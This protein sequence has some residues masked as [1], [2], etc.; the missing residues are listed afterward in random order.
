MRSW[1]F[2]ISLGIHLFFLG[3]LALCPVGVHIGA[4]RGNGVVAFDV[5]EPQNQPT[6]SKAGIPRAKTPA[7]QDEGLKVAKSQQQAEAST[8]Q[9]KTL[10]TNSQPLGAGF[11]LRDAASTLPPAL[12]RY[13]AELRRAIEQNKSYPALAKR[14]R[15]SGQVAI[16]FEINPDGEIKNIKLEKASGFEALNQSALSAVKTVAEQRFPLPDSF[17]SSGIVVI[18]PINYRL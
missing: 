16:R 10:L 14:F 6:D 15:Q 1:F 5:L 17:N 18:L 12:Q 7:R 4:Q 2:L 3:M 13:F 8:T 9:R 11:D